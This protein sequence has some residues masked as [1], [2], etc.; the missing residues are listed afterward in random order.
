MRSSD[1]HFP[2][3]HLRPPLNWVNDPNG[4][5]FHDG[6][7]HVFFQYNPASPRH[8]STHWGHWRS[9]DLLTWELLPIALTPT[10]GGPDSAGA[11]SGNAISHDNELVAFYAARSEDQWWQPVA[12]ARSDDGVTFHKDKALAVAEPPPGTVMF[13]DP[14]VW[15]DGDGWRMLVGAALD[16]G[17]GAAIQYVSTDLTDWTLLGPY[18]ACAPVP[19]V[20]H[21]TTEEGWECVQYADFG[22]HRGAILFSAWG[23]R[24][25]ASAVGIL[26]GEDHGTSFEPAA[27]QPFDFGP[28]AYAPALLRAPDGR[29]LAWAWIWEARDEERVGAPSLWT[30]EV[31]WAGMLSLPRELQLCTDRVRQS[32]A[33]EIA[34]LRTQRRIATATSVTTNEEVDLGTVSRTAD[35]LV[36]LDRSAD[37][38][39][40]SGV[41]LVTSAD[42]NEHLD[43][44]L[45][46][47][48]GDLVVDRT[49]AS[50]DDR[51]KKGQW[52]IPTAVAPGA[53][54]ELRALVDRSVVEIFTETGDVL[55]LRFY[56]TGADEWHLWATA[57]GA[58]TA[59]VVAE[60]WDL[61]PLSV[62]DWDRLDSATGT[63]RSRTRDLISN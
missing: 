26:V 4:L 21:R 12:V 14:Y 54:V 17:R 51:A 34:G 61:A 30:D 48:T 16:D 8:S 56:P 52:R 50:R 53:S 62:R 36:V 44:H 46:L 57:E 11:W 24:E 37:G 9:E 59:T 38:Q 18:A 39:A 19:L 23:P 6:C 49:E 22:G 32:P 58:G 20:D 41:R 3:I 47:A 25:G 33:R 1:P 27:L 13:R 10:P 28:D 29:W 35:L 31:G 15:R 2:A 55:T 42:R 63:E 40:A 45:D 60:A 7:Y 5:A 43:L